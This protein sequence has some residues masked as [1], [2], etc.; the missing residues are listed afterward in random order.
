MGLNLQKKEYVAKWLEFPVGNRAY[1]GG[2]WSRRAKYKPKPELVTIKTTNVQFSGKS[3]IVN[4][5]RKLKLNLYYSDGTPI[6]ED[7]Y[8]IS[9]NTEDL[10]EGLNLPKKS[11]SDLDVVLREMIQNQMEKDKSEYSYPHLWKDVSWLTTEIAQFIRS[12]YGTSYSYLML[13]L[14][15][16]KILASRDEVLQS[17]RRLYPEAFQRALNLLQDTPNINEGLNL[18]KSQKCPVCGSTDT[19]TDYDNPQ[20]M[21]ICNQCRSEWTNDG[22]ITFNGREFKK[23]YIKKTD[24]VWNDYNEEETGL[25]CP[26]CGSSD[27]DTWF[28][29]DQPANNQ[30]ATCRDCGYTGPEEEFRNPLQEQKKLTMGKLKLLEVLTPQDIQLIKSLASTE[31]NK[32]KSEL[33]PTIQKVEKDLAQHSQNKETHLK[34]KDVKDIIKPEIDK[35]KEDLNTKIDDKVTKVEK[36]IDNKIEKSKNDKDLDKKVKEMI[37]DVMVKYHQTLWVKRGF[38]TS[39]LTK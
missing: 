17:L 10:A 13:W 31:A 24:E 19:R 4:G 5:I 32:V 9:F 16:K 34:N 36:T 21:K 7:Y 33:K 23:A 25:I 12:N 30:A 2:G 3:V 22:D 14:R 20:S 8:N 27:I 39:G 15:T 28:N 26:E 29:S 1:G 6:R 37:A 11:I 18:P 38:W 35:T